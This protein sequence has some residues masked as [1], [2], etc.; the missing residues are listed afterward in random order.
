MVQSTDRMY[1]G[2]C[3]PSPS[4][5][6]VISIAS[7][8]TLLLIP[9]TCCCTCWL[10]GGWFILSPSLQAEILQA[11][12]DW[13][14]AD[15]GH[16]TLY[17]SGV[18]GLVYSESLQ[19]HLYPNYGEVTDFYRVESMRGVYITSQMSED[20]SIHS[21]ITYNRGAT[22]QPLPR[23]QGAMCKDEKKVSQCPQDNLVCQCAR[24]KQIGHYV[25]ELLVTGTEGNNYLS[26]LTVT[27]TKLYL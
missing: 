10:C 20:D 18:R 14:I 16:G 24:T 17:T 13:F 9:S 1:K 2:W 25:Q 22:W 23:P 27:I 21:M 4:F 7:L 8:Q 19:K 6:A 26:L 15:T 11:V 3:I 12:L 5:Q